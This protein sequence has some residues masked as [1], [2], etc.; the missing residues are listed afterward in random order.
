MEQKTEQNEKATK[1]QKIFWL[2]PLIIFI[3]FISY[4]MIRT[5]PGEVK[6]TIVD[7]P[8][9]TAGFVTLS[10]SFEDVLE[11]D[12]YDKDY[13]INLNGLTTK[14]LGINS[15]NERQK[16]ENGYLALFEEPQDTQRDSNY[17]IE[18]NQFL[19][20]RDIPF[21]F[22]LAPGKASFYDAQTA[23]GYNNEAGSNIDNMINVLTDAGVPCLDMDAWFEEN[24][25][26]IEDVFFKTDHHWLPQAGLQSARLTMD[27]LS[28]LGEVQYDPETLK[29]ENWTVI[30]LPDWSLGSDGKRT[31]I[32]Y[33]GVDDFPVYF[34][35]YATDYTYSYLQF[36]SKGWVYTDSPLN[37]SYMDYKDYFGSSV[38]DTYLYNNYPLQKITNSDAKNAQKVLIIGDSYRLPYMYFLS[39]QFQEI[40]GIDVR[41]YTDGSA[42]QYIEELQPD[43][44]LMCTAVSEVSDVRIYMFGVSSYLTALDETD[45]DTDIVRLGDYKLEAGE[46]DQDC[47]TRVEASL[48]R[49]QTYTLTVDS[50]AY[51]GGED[52]YVQMTLQDLSTDEAVYNRYFDINSDEIQRW[53]FTVPEDTKDEYGIYF[54][55][56]TKEH[57]AG[58]TAELQNVTLRKGIFEK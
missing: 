10:D 29:E 30:T 25:W 23:P 3:A 13:Y 34:P 19:N 1:K 6:E 47:L 2:I 40:Y 14:V 44:V 5:I 33:A 31:G 39:T 16:L 53:I 7:T 58:V 56:G 15:L 38:Y 50:T 27:Y 28:G 54:Y 21:L 35:N 48:E 36:H 55:A 37:L 41:N 20:E 57:T 12:I 8:V 26:T 45:M 4:M 22:I 11:D 52:Q 32:A 49:G 43:I 17:V 42:A 51:S 9:S 24:K 18:L 46:G